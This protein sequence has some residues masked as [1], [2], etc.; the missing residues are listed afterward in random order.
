VS[1]RVGGRIA[2][3]LRNY[4]EDSEWRIS[5]ILLFALLPGIGFAVVAGA[6]PTA[7][8]FQ[9]G[10][11]M[12]GPDPIHIIERSLQVARTG[13]P[14]TVDP[15][16]RYLPT[17]AGIVIAGATTDY[18]LASIVIHLISTLSAY[19]L[20]PFA[21]AMLATELVD[22]RAGLATV[23]A[24]YV[25]R[26][27]HIGVGPY[28]TSRWHYAI[29]LA[30]A[31]ATVHTLHL[32]TEHQS[33]RLAVHTG[34]GIGIVGL[35]ELVFGVVLASG[36]TVVYFSKG[37]TREWAI[38]GAVGSGFGSVL[39]FAPAAVNHALSL[40]EGSSNVTGRSVLEIVA[41]TVGE[42]TALGN[43]LIIVML[44][45]V[46]AAR[47]ATG[48]YSNSVDGVVAFTVVFWVLTKLTGFSSSVGHTAQFLL[49]NLLLAVCAAYLVRVADVLSNK[50][51]T[52]LF[53]KPFQ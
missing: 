18:T 11:P 27:F 46:F 13:S 36:A 5:V 37:L 17:A 53:T 26:A 32:S 43:T 42:L 28:F 10:T 21:L 19:L 38:C 22:L 30:V 33:N 7:A 4:R 24:F 51:S 15:P 47:L 41:T 20:L 1:E 29:P 2:E 8:F 31:F 9:P 16:F 40:T 14:F 35:Q 49:Y 3:I 6:R 45:F 52:P 25:V 12:W 39:F 50:S 44:M 34:L 23:V 48:W